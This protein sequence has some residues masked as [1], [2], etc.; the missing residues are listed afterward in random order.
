MRK[1]ARHLSDLIAE[2]ALQSAFAERSLQHADD[3]GALA[4]RAQ[5][6]LQVAI[7]LP[8]PSV[9]V[10]REAKCLELF[11]AS[12]T[13]CVLKRIAMPGC[14]HSAEAGIPDQLSVN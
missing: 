9:E 10:L 4:H 11:K 1:R 6:F 12:G 14:D 2:R 3:V 7:E 5:L 13:Q 8:P